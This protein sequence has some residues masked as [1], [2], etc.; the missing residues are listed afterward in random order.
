M[1]LNNR[2]QSLVMFILIIPILL[3]IM[4]MVMDIGNVIYNKQ[5]IDNINKI[6]IS[7][8][9]TNMDDVNIVREMENLALL[10]NS[11]MPFVVEI[12]QGQIIVDSTYYVKGVF[13]KIFATDGYL[14]RSKYSGYLTDK[15]KEKIVKIK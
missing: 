4:A 8:G 5:D 7:Y 2:G 9:L 13:S 10:N 15:G 6:V 3:G 14:V 1:Q 11:D 12:N